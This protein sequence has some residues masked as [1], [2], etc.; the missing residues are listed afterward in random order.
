MNFQPAFYFQT[1][2]LRPSWI[3][4]L[5]TEMPALLLLLICFGIYGFCVFQFHGL[6]LYAGLFFAIY[7]LSRAIHIARVEYIITGEQIIVHQG[8]L[9]HSTDYME[10]YRVV[11]Y[12][13][14]QSLPQ[15]LFRLKTVSIF[16]GDRNC[17]QLDMIGIHQDYDVVSE[18]RF[19]VEFNKRRKGIYEFTNKS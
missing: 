15:Q 14:Q 9:F 2:I 6:F 1:I 3:Q 5:L 18:I 10:L 19:R 7:L 4:F 8:V 17:P 13:Q 12:Q 16:S 11:D